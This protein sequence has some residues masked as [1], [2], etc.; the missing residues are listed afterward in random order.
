[1]NVEIFSEGPAPVIAEVCRQIGLVKTIDKMTCWDEDR[2]KISPGLRM[3]AV[4]VNAL[5]DRQPLMYLPPFFGDMDVQKLFGKG[6][7]PEDINDHAVGRGLDKL[8]QAGPERVYARI[9]MRTLIEED[10]KVDT[11]HADTTSM[12]VQG[13]YETDDEVLNLTHGYSKDGRPDLKQF[14]YGLGVTPDGVPVVAQ[15]RDGNTADVTW[16]GDIVEMLREKVGTEDK[17]T[18][19]L[20]VADSK[21][22]SKTNLS[23][24]AEENLH[25]ISRLPGTFNLD[26]ELKARA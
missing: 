3:V 1:M 10:V 11:I 16:N 8:A 15:V 17:G 20:Y 9:A 5:M 21:L 2:C 12:S 24:L 26:E 25:F 6:V 13:T 4:I 23:K 18:P 19:L 22:V 14:L 7:Q